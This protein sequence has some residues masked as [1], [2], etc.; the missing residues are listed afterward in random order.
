LRILIMGSGGVGGVFGARLAKGG[1]DVTFVA[2]GAHLDAMRKSGLRI[3]GGADPIA[4]PK[5]NATDDPA[6]AGPVDMIL[7]A[8]KLWDTESAARTLLPCFGPGTGLISFQNGVQK[9]DML[10][11]IVGDKALLGGVSYVS[12]AIKEPG[13]ITQTGP[14]QGLVFGEFDGRPSKRVEDFLAACLAGGIDA[15]ISP[16]INLVIWQKFV[17]LASVAGTTTSMRAPIGAI[18]DHPLTRQFLLDLMQEIVAVGRARGV[19]LAPDFAEERMR[20]ADTLPA[21]MIASMYHDL[22]TGKPLELPW[23]NGSVVDL[24]AEAGV[25]TPLNRAVRDVLILHAKGK[26]TT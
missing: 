24:G 23:L 5:V 17:F 9:D 25:P 22:Q 11:P 10:R 16:D 18:R 14:M 2:R 15:K 19:A 26:A 21:G 3:E 4:L 12:A 1:A 7:F 8:V 6:T 20:F 13:V